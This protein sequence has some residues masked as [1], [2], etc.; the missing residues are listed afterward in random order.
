MT[1]FSKGDV[2]FWNSHFRVGGW[3]GSGNIGTRCQTQNTSNCKAVF[4]MLH[5]AATSSTYIENM[6]GWTADHDID[7]STPMNIASVRGVLISATGGTWLVGT[8]S[9]ISSALEKFLIIPL[10][11]G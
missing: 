9:C 6:W 4:L 7:S 8:V 3:V 10:I 2:G 11:L 1:G 5:L